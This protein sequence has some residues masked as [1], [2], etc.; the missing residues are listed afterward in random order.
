[1]PAAPV[2]GT[3]R[4][5]VALPQLSLR[6]GRTG[7]EARALPAALRSAAEGAQE[8]VKHR[9]VI[10]HLLHTLAIGGVEILPPRLARP[11]QDRYRFVFACLDASGPLG[12]ELVAEG[13]PVRVLGR[14]P[15]FDWTCGMR[16]GALLHHHRI[17]LIHAH[18]YGPFL[19][20]VLAR[21]LCRRPA[22]LFA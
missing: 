22:I 16:L 5:P 2:C 20:A 13:F 11:L 15:G 4:F 18:T 7:T 6:R 12:Q 14:R 1:Y 21:I 9:A 8:T 17:D 10:C 3:G 19:Y